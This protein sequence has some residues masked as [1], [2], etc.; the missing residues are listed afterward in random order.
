MS[1]NIAGVIGYIGAIGAL[2]SVLTAALVVI[3]GASKTSHEELKRTFEKSEKLSNLR[4]DSLERE[5]ES[6]RPLPARVAKLEKMVVE[7]QRGVPILLKQFKK[8]NIK[9]EWEPAEHL[10]EEIEG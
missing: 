2:V 8:H 4:I 6:L 5:L 9:P 10:L 3:F 1:D 7:F